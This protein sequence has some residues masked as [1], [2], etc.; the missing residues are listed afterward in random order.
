MNL[1]PRILK[2]PNNMPVP[3]AIMENFVTAGSNYQE[4]FLALLATLA[5]SKRANLNV[6]GATKPLCILIEC[7]LVS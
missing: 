7:V 6:S 4:Q 2:P 3:R 5:E 1:T